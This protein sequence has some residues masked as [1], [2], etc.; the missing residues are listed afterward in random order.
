M[1]YEYENIN[2]SEI[3]IEVLDCLAN[4]NIP[5]GVY[6]VAGKIERGYSTANVCLNILTSRKLI[7]KIRTMNNKTVYT[8]NRDNVKLEKEDSTDDETTE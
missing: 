5:L 2:L 3:D 7:K 6:D 1:K 8:L 4:S